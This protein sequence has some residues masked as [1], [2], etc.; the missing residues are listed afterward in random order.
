M[1][2]LRRSPI[3]L[4]SAGPGVGGEPENS[5]RPSFFGKLLNPTNATISEGRGQRTI[6]NDDP[7]E[8]FDDGFE[9]G[10][11]TAWSSTVGG[12]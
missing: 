8:I 6:R 9:T 11:P 5:E 4:I 1:S 3:I 10:N 7:D 12:G 2:A